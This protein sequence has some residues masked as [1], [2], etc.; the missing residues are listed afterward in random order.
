MKKLDANIFGY[1]F[2][3]IVT[4]SMSDTIK[5]GD[6]VI[7]KLGKDVTEGDIIAYQKDGEVIVHRLIEKNGDSFVTKGDANNATDEPISEKQI[8]GKVVKIL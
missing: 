4:G 2:Y 8:L 3:N 6:K 5:I 1:S 7:V